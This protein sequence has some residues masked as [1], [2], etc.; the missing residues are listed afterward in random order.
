MG[1]PVEVFVTSLEPE[2]RAIV[3][4][5]RALV[6]HVVPDAEETLLWGGISYHTPWVGGRV[7]GSVCQI[8]AKRGE[9]RL[10]FIHGVRLEDPARLLRGDRRSKRHVVIGSAADVARPEIA[11]LIA[12]ASATDPWD[13]EESRSRG[14]M[15]RSDSARGGKR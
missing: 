13:A 7:R 2:P 4:A 3:A 6:R 12:A 14:M 8:A 11:A 10:E 1:T 15:A 5:L 9:V